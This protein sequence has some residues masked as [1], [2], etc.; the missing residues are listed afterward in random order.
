MQ[1]KAKK[2][3]N[4]NK[5]EKVKIYSDTFI[6]QLCISTEKVI[7]IITEKS[8]L[9][10]IVK[11]Q[12]FQLFIQLAFQDRRGRQQSKNQQERISGS[13]AKRSH[14]VPS[15]TF[16]IPKIT[17]NTTHKIFISRHAILKFQIINKILT[18]L[19]RHLK[20]GVEEDWYQISHQQH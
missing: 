17:Q 16:L 8:A 7:Y 1:Q 10:I 3:V 20:E 12:I 6:Y 14:Q 2:M 13:S 11:I 15:R 9:Y 5:K 4:L 19:R 18:T